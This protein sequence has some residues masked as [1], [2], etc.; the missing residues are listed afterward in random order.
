MARRI[1]LEINLQGGNRTAAEVR[2]ITERFE[3]LQAQMQALENVSQQLG[4]SIEDT[5]N[6]LGALGL[7]AEQASRAINGLL[8]EQ[9]G[10][11]EAGNTIRDLGLTETQG[12]VLR[13]VLGNP[14]DIQ[15]YI[16]LLNGLD[17]SLEAVSEVARITGGNI[18][19][20][21]EF[22]EQLGLSAEETARALRT[23]QA[24]QRVGADRD[25]QRQNLR[26]LGLN[27]DQTT[28]ILD[29]VDRGLE[30]SGNGVTNLLTKIGLLSFG[31][32]QAL[33]ALQTFAAGGAQAYDALIGQN[34]RLRQQILSVQSSLVANTDVFQGSQQIEDP[35]SAI[36][37]LEEPVRSALKNIER[38]SLEL[39]GVVSS[40]LVE[41]F[42][43]LTQQTDAISNQS[44]E[45]ADPIEAASKLTID[46]AA[47][48]GILGVPLN[49]AR[50]EIQSILTMTIDQ[51]S[52][53]AKSLG[54]TND[55]VRS[56]Q[57]QGKL[58]DFLRERLQPFVEGNALAAKSVSGITS[59]LREVFEIVT[60]T[61]GEPLY[62]EL[63]EQLQRVYDFVSQNQEAI[64]SSVQSA[65]SFLQELLNTVLQG[66][67]GIA[68]KLQ[69]LALDLK[70]TLEVIASKGAEQIL[71]FVELLFAA[72]NQILTLLQPLLDLL[73]DILQV[74]NNFGL[75]EVIVQGTAIV[76]LL[77]ALD[78]ALAAMAGTLFKAVIPA[79]VATATAIAPLLPL[80]LAVGTAVTV[81]Q[82]FKLGKVN[83]AI[84]AYS[85]SVKTAGDESFR[86]A[87]QLKELNDIEANGGTLTAEQVKQKEALTAA[88][89]D[90]IAQNSAQIAELKN[91]KT[92][93]DSQAN[94]VKALIQQLEISNNALGKQAGL[95][96]ETADKVRVQSR[97]LQELG[98]AYD[99]IQSKIDGNLEAIKRGTGDLSQ[100]QRQAQETIDLTQKQ[101]EAGVIST[102]AAI[103]NLQT[104]ASNT[105]LTYEEQL[106]AQKAIFA[107]LRAEAEETNEFIKQLENEKLIDL[108][109]LL[110]ARLITE[111]EFNA[112]RSQLTTIRIGEELAAEQE[113]LR[114][115]DALDLSEEEKQEERR[116]AIAKTTELQLQLLYSENA[117]R[118][119]IVDLVRE[120]E[121][122]IDAQ[123]RRETSAIVSGLRQQQDEIGK[124]NR[125]LEQRK[126]AQDVIIRS[127]DTENRLINSIAEVERAR[128]NLV[129]TE[130]NVERDRL[131]KILA[132]RERLNSGEVRSAKERREI[133]RELQ[134]L[135]GFNI[136][137]TEDYQKRLKKLEDERFKRQVEAQRAEQE[138]SR[139]L[140]ELEIKKNE[141]AA[142]RAVIEAKIA[143]NQARQAK[144]SAE[145]ELRTQNSELRTREGELRVARASQD[146]EAI[147]DAED[148]LRL[149]QEEYDRRF[150]AI[151]LSSDAV[152]LATA[153]VAEAEKQVGV[154]AEIAENSRLALELQER[155]AEVQLS[156]EAKARGQAK[157][158]K[159]GADQAI[160]LSTAL[161]SITN[162]EL[163]ITNSEKVIDGKLVT[164][165]F[166]DST[167]PL[168]TAGS[169]SFRSADSTLQGNGGFATR[170]E[171][172][173]R[174]GA[175]EA[176]RP[177]IV[178]E[179]AGGRFIPGVSEIVVPDTDSYAIAAVEAAKMFSRG[180]ERTQINNSYISNPVIDSTRQLKDAVNG[181]RNDLKN[182]PTGTV[183]NIEGMQFINN[184]Q[185]RSDK[186]AAMRFVRDLAD[187][188]E[189]SLGDF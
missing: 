2:S 54:I 185:D 70:D 71:G 76:G 140:L 39:V 132:L 6:L 102:E 124:V 29:R 33:Q 83:E 101:L 165:G 67:E 160:R 175:M 151:A 99:Q 82:G 28:E 81:L 104:I 173:F 91:L 84:D 141:A 36:L 136:I 146:K 133:V 111:G 40:D 58:V 181:L 46:F 119:A 144:L 30:R 49:Q 4:T 145:I 53:L 182:L 94:S 158:L 31:F 10:L 60:R 154:Q 12:D 159:E 51:N 139:K 95:L 147:A 134:R 73:G 184:L 112:K 80:L 45:F 150:E 138:R 34:E 186:G 120:R 135:D 61:A 162:Y 126:V 97:A 130:G 163:R 103:A 148:R 26:N 105:K 3:E 188:I 19:E 152:D 155:A 164:I 96:D 85:N 153:N 187:E 107:A 69:P 161:N 178:G 88:S 167:F 156:A 109:K 114:Q 9:Q 24:G 123:I 52:V 180:V 57:Q 14:G 78:I 35:R 65:V 171:G 127:L 59:N 23:V 11:R 108:Q 43:I 66:I 172:R 143:E 72:I 129:E 170:I 168:G 42:S 110:N 32:N 179:G 27:E 142:A 128:R 22:I 116:K 8:L 86:Y 5:E 177:Y 25:T 121:R 87:Q 1:Q 157:A 17:N 74:M 89:K 125:L 93:N 77:T 92:E 48:L 16:N 174:G 64:A 117:E 56:Y 50:Q 18:R 20:A 149:A 44:A 122:L 47:T 68:Q 183:N 169:S 118:E 98:S 106:A 166:A 37:A 131:T 189:R 15:Q 55:Q 63:V 176:G 21:E 41:V 79:A 13:N 62:E 100:I 38:D 115:I 137:A 7:N 90:L 113:R 75:T